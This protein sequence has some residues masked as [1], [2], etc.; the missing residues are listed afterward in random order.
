MY[1]K[2]R[3]KYIESDP[4]EQLFWS[5][6]IEGDKKL[7]PD[8]KTFE[9]MVHSFLKQNMDIDLA[10]E[11]EDVFERLWDFP[12]R[13]AA[14]NQGNKTRLTSPLNLIHGYVVIELL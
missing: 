13:S 3:R 11:N 5:R 4:Q 2:G 10:A 6:D 7:L 12:I 1:I 9:E 14:I 8:F